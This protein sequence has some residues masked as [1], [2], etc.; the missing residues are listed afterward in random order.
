MTLD[1]AV[2]EC[3][4]LIAANC[5]AY[6]DPWA[7]K[8]AHFIVDTLGQQLPC[9]FDEPRAVLEDDET[10]AHVEWSFGEEMT[11]DPDEAIAIGAALMRAGL[12]AKGGG[13]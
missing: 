6:V 8:M 10:T 12:A 13:R 11:L 2:S 1:E 9:G 4:A 7:L 3:R 5:T